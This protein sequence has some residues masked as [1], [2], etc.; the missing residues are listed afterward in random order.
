M[1]AQ[2]APWARWR[3]GAAAGAG[4]EAGAVGGALYSLVATPIAN[5]LRNDRAS[6][7]RATIRV[8][9]KGLLQDAFGGWFPVLYMIFLVCFGSFLGINLIVAVIFTSFCGTARKLASSD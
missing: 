9:T 2:P 8:L 3:D 4:A 7:R 1:A 6:G 5:F